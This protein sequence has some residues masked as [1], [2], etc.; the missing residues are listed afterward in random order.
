VQAS[1]RKQDAGTEPFRAC[2]CASRASPAG[3]SRAS[4]ITLDCRLRIKQN[5][6]MEAGEYDIELTRVGVEA[7]KD[8]TEPNAVQYYKQLL[9]PNVRMLLV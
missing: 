6:P 4:V 1:G 7:E 8:S 2:T 3:F 9:L 5:V